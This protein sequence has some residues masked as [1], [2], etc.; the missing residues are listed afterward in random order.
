MQHWTFLARAHLRQGAK[1]LVDPEDQVIFDDVLEGR[2]TEPTSASEQQRHGVEFSAVDYENVFQNLIAYQ[3]AKSPAPLVSFPDPTNSS[4]D[5][6]QYHAQGG[7]SGVFFHIQC[8]DGMFNYDISHANK[9][10]HLDLTQGLVLSAVFEVLLSSS[11]LHS[12]SNLTVSQQTVLDVT[13][14]QL[15]TRQVS[16]SCTTSHDCYNTIGSA[17]ISARNTEMWQNSAALLP[18]VILEV[19]CAG[20]GWVYAP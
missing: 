13:I 2:I 18:C 7:W 8:L 4:V 16:T 10:R 6:F 11:I 1:V 20:V 17:Q 12:S 3:K 9:Q 5:H 15:C 19:V 14:C